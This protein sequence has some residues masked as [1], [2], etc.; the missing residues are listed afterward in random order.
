MKVVYEDQGDPFLLQP[1][2]CVIQPPE[3]RHRVLESSSGLTVIEIGCPAE[4]ETF[5]EHDLKLPNGSQ[6]PTR[7][8]LGQRF[9]KHG[10]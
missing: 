1:G 6:I 10:Q 7:N 8:F 2:D 3:I 4:H 5:V 9:V